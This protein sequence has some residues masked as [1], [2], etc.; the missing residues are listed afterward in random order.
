MKPG[1]FYAEQNTP[2]C[3]SQG[4]RGMIMI[5]NLFLLSTSSINQ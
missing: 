2:A 3:L 4:I 5:L 1:F